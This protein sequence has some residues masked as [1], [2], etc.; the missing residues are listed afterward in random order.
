M[1]MQLVG[2]IL[3]QPLSSPGKRVLKQ[4][5]LCGR[6]SDRLRGAG[7]CML[8]FH[9]YKQQQEKAITRY[10]AKMDFHG[11]NYSREYR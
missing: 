5:Q 7:S 4:S 8:L 6:R 1:D 3:P 11:Y 10:L 2:N 9:N